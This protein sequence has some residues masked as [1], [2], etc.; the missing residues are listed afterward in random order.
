MINNH[1][2]QNNKGIWLVALIFIVVSSLLVSGCGAEEP[3]VYRVGVLD[4]AESFSTTVDGFKAKMT[5]LGYVEGENIVYD[6][7]SVGPDLADYQRITEKF[8]A[9]EV[10]LI[11][12]FPTEAATAAKAATQDTNI[13]VIFAWAP[14]EGTGLVESVRQPGGNIT[15][16]RVSM[17]DLLYKRLELLLELVPTAKRIWVP[18][19]PKI[20]NGSITPVVEA[21]RSIASDAGVT[22]IETQL[23]TFEDFEADLQA[24]DTASDLDFEAIMLMPEPIVGSPDGWALMSEFAAKH[25]IPLAAQSESQVDTRAIFSFEPDN[26]QAGELAAILADKILRGTPAGTIPVVTIDGSLR[27]NYKAAQEI[28]LTVPDSILV[29]ADEIIR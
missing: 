22:L 3:Q 12:A 14:T 16:V 6:V 17:A 24:L 20:A 25:N 9:D 5:G 8:V 7:Q 11:F 15:G 4:G 18:Y 29:Q 2:I 27:V 21:M 26:L 13:P 1:H 23:T 19:D 10:D 28:G